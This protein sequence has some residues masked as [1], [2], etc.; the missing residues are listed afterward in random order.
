[1]EIALIALVASVAVAGCCAIAKLGP[2]RSDP[3][4]GTFE[5]SGSASLI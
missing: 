1:M 2:T 4:S 5:S 3:G